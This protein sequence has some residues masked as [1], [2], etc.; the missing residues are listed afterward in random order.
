M[1]HWNPGTVA[2]RLRAREAGIPGFYTCAGRARFFD[3]EDTEKD[4]ALSSAQLCARRLGNIP[5]H[6]GVARR[7]QRIGNAVG[8][9]RCIGPRWPIMR[10]WL[11]LMRP[12]GYCFAQLSC[13]P[14]LFAI[15]CGVRSPSR[16]RP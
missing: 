5:A 16:R 10:R 13:C 15:D 6:V 11:Q 7:H 4:V 2:E 1:N 9:C 8:D 3:R 12:G 14:A